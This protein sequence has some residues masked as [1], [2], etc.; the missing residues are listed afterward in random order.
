MQVTR[1]QYDNELEELRNMV[2]TMG[3]EADKALDLAMQALTQR[4]VDLAEQVIQNDDVL[5]QLDL[6]IESHCIRILALQQ[7]I[8]RD[9]RL[10][11]TAMKIV[12]DLERIGDHSVDIAKVA[13]KLA[14]SD[15]HGPLADFPKMA[16]E[17]RTMLHKSLEAFVKHD[18]GLVEEVV[19]ADDKVDRMYRMIREDLHRTMQSSSSLVVEGSYLLFVAHYL[20]RTADHSV[21][22]AERVYFME[23]GVLTQL[24]KSHK[25]NS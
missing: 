13:R 11:G 18:L 21:N 24:A 8:A 2:L 14:G 22:I 9:L 19:D 1:N 7:P 5:D 16:S 12:T 6:D 4:N 15:G 20:E 25:A 3:S 17:V 10:V 23:T